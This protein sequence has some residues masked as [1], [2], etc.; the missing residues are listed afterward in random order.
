MQ[1]RLA[2]TAIVTVL[3]VMVVPT[4]RSPAHAA[5]AQPLR[6]AATTFSVWKGKRARAD[7]IA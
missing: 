7:A 2:P 1:R 4:L 6:P 3:A 5:G